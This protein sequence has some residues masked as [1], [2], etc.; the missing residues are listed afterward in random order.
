MWTLRT[1]VASVGAH[2]LLLGVFVTMAESR[3]PPQPPKVKRDTVEWNLNPVKVPPVTHL[4]KAGERHAVRGD[5]NLQP[6]DEVPDSV[7]P[8]NPNDTPVG[9]L[10]GHGP[11]AYIA[12]TPTPNSPPRR[13]DTGIFP[14]WSDSGPIPADSAEVLPHLIDEREAQ[15]MLQRVYPPLLRDQGTTGRT[16][17]RLIIDRDGNVKPGSVQVRETTHRGFDEAAVRAVEKFHFTPAEFRGH[18]VSVE[19]AI[20]IEW[21][22]QR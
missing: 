7:M 18:P 6:P 17:V 22:L 15:R 10:T 1:V 9:P 20:P 12:G 19:I 16:T 2:L 5:P 21:Q 8:A 3:L 11:V 13:G 4:P 14:V